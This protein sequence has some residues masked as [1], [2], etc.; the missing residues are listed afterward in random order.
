MF[1]ERNIN[2]IKSFE[3]ERFINKRQIKRREFKYLIR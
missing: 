2:K 1:V 3:I